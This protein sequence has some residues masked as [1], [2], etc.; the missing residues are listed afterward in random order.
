MSL[1]WGNYGYPFLWFSAIEGCTPFE[2]SPGSREGFRA[3]RGGGWGEP[4]GSPGPS[5]LRARD[6]R[7]ARTAPGRGA[8]AVR[9][10]RERRAAA[11]RTRLRALRARARLHEAAGEGR[12]S[13]ALA[14][15]LD[16]P[17]DRR[18]VPQERHR[19]RRLRGGRTSHRRLRPADHP[20][21]ASAFRMTPPGSVGAGAQVSQ[22]SIPR[23]RA[24]SLYASQPTQKPV[25]AERRARPATRSPSAHPSVVSPA[26]CAIAAEPSTA[27][28]MTLA[29]RGGRASSSGPS[30]KRGWSS[31]KYAR[32]GRQNR[33]PSVRPTTSCSARRPSSHDCPV[34]MATAETIPIVAWFDR[35]ARESI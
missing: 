3:P 5:K 4:K 13:R 17:R 18:H 30:P 10:V 28:P 7:L 25:A 35:G 19:R 34:A 11:A 26:A 29:N 22:S 14:L 16:I 2:A 21:H 32:H 1:E 27:T 15:A 23:T 6:G 33:R 24:R 12:P 9:G 20:S 8:G 31:S